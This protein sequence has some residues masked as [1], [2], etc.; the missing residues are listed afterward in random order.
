MLLNESQEETEVKLQVKRKQ[1][2]Q[3]ML[4]KQK[5]QERGASLV[6]KV[7]K[8]ILKKIQRNAIN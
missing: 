1:S 5:C 3:K 4:K 2:S 6:W 7:S 8:I